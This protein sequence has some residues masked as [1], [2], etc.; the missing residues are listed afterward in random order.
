MR[1]DS[2]T[3]EPWRR[4]GYAVQQ[5]IRHLSVSPAAKQLAN[6]LPHLEQ[7][8]KY[9]YYIFPAYGPR[10]TIY[11]SS[12]ASVRVHYLI[13]RKS[14]ASLSAIWRSGGGGATDASPGST[15]VYIG[16]GLQ[17]SCKPVRLQ[18]YASSSDFLRLFS[19]YLHQKCGWDVFQIRR[20]MRL[21]MEPLLVF[22]HDDTN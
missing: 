1:F 18:D 20:G 7:S 11:Q 6:Y 8:Y 4:Q 15:R 5:A 12:S 3:L 14:T 17:P 2:R 9:V 13:A 21:V 19:G 16:V 22:L 10:Q